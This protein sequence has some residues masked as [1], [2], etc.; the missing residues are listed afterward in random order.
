MKK[1]TKKVIRRLRHFIGHEMLRTKPTAC[2]DWS[3]TDNYPLLLVGFTSDGC[4][5]Y[6][7]TG[8]DVLIFGNKEF[9]LPLHFTDYNWITYKKAITAK[10][11]VLNKW[12]GKKIRRIRP[13]P[14]FGF[15]SFM[16]GTAPT[17]ISASKHH[18]VILRNGKKSILRWVYARSEDWE[19]AE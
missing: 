6:R 7:H 1:S 16:S 2:G 11:N 18:I 10:G 3:F 5:R 19:L 12:Q 17:L 14:I 9:V 4:I 13:T 8:M 15:C